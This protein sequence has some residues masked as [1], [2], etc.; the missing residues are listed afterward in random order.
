M[1]ERTAPTAT[2]RATTPAGTVAVTQEQLIRLLQEAAPRQGPWSE[3]DYLRLTDCTNRLIEWTDGCIEV[4]PMPTDEHQS[5]AAHLY[6]AFLDF[7]RV[8]GGD[9]GRSQLGSDRRPRTAQRADVP[10]RLPY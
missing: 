4:L 8:R 2:A 7:V 10:S 5:I 3:D 9:T 1:T 6:E